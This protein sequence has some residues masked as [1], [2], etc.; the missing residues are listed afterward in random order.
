M[1]SATPP[2]AVDGRN[3]TP[4]EGFPPV[5]VIGMGVRLPDADTVE[6]LHALLLK[7]H[8]AVRP[9]PRRRLEMAGLDPDGVH[10]PMATLEGIDE[11]DRAFFGITPAEAEAMDPHQRL[12]LQLACAAV[13]NAGY[14]LSALRGR[15][16]GVFLSAPRPEYTALVG[17][18]SLLTMLGTAAPALAGR[19][20]Y[21]LGLRGP[22]LALET[23]CSSSLVALHYACRELAHGT[24][25]VALAGGL[26]LHLLPL[27][28]S[29]AAAFPEVMAA[30]GRCRAFDASAA[31][32]CQGEG[33]ALLLLKPLDR[34]L[35][36]GDTVHAVIRAIAVNHN[37]DRSNGFSAPGLPAQTEVITQAWRQAG[38][39]PARMDVLEAHGS[40]TRLGD[41]IEIEAVQRVLSAAGAGRH[42]C[43]V[44]SVKTNLGHLDHAAGITGLAKAILAVR[45]R[46][47][48][49]SL[50]FE[51]PNP[52]L[53]AHGE[54]IHV[55]TTARP[56]QGP[57]GVPMVAAVSAFSLTGTNVH[58]VVEGPPAPAGAPRAA[59]RADLTTV[60]AAT[61]AALAGR[62]ERL[63]ERVSALDAADLPDVQFTLNTGRD[64]HPCRV[65]FPAGDPEA[66]RSG[67]RDA[68]AAGGDG[69]AEPTVDRRLVLVIGEPGEHAPEPGPL[70]DA[71]PAYRDAWRECGPKVPPAVAHQYATGRLLRAVG[72]A[73]AVVVGIGSGKA[74]ARAL[75]GEL[76]LSEALAE[77]ASAPPADPAA[78]DAKA[79]EVAARL[80]GQQPSVLCLLG[81]PGPAFTSR[82]H[83]RWGARDRDGV[84]AEAAR[85]YET[86]VTP[87]WETWYAG[88]TR[89]R[90]E[91]PGY[92][93]AATPCWPEVRAAGAPAVAPVPAVER[94]APGGTADAE[95][96]IAGIW[97]SVLKIPGIE[98]LGEDTDY[99]ELGGNSILGLAVLERL[100]Q[101]FGVRL[102]L[103]ALY[104][105][106]TVRDLAAV[107]RGSGAGSA[108]P[109]GAAIPKAPRRE[110]YLPSHGQDALWFL[111]QLMPGLP[112]YNV[113][114]DLHLSGVLDVDA[115][116]TALA[117]LEAR[118]EVL[119]TRYVEVDGEP[120]IVLRPVDERELE[121]VD[122]SGSADPQRRLA[123]AVRLLRE[124]AAAPMDLT[125][126]PLYRKLLVR[127]AADDHILLLVA[128]H[129][130][131]DGWTPAILDRDLWE[132]Y[133]AAVQG[134]TPDLPDLPIGYQDFAAWQRER[135]AGGR[136]EELLR[137]WRAR[138]AGLRPLD[139]PDARPR[140]ERPSGR[141]AHYYFT[142]PAAVMGGLRALSSQQRTTLFTTMLTSLKTL[143]ARYSGVEDVVV[144]TTTAGRSV[145]E[146]L[147]LIGYFN[148]AV[149]LRTDLSGDPSF[150]DALARVR[151]T[152][153]GALE[154]DELPFSMLVADLQPTRDV[155][156]HPLFQIT[157]VHQ[158]LPENARD[159][160]PGL[161]YHPD[162][163]E[164]FAGLPPG[165]AKWDLSLAVWE[166]DGRAELPAVL[167][168][169]LD[170]FEEPQIARLA[171][172]FLTLLEGIVAD[173]D[174]PLSRLPLLD[175]PRRRTVLGGGR[176][177][178][179]RDPD[180]T[181]PAL[182]A[183]SAGESDEGPVARLHADAGRL[184][185]AL[186]AR[187]VRPGDPVAGLLGGERAAVALLGALTAGAVYVP[188]DPQLS[189]A[190]RA[191]VLEHAA[192]VLLVTDGDSV[193]P[194]P[195]AVLRMPDG[196]LPDAPA[197]EA[198]SAHRAA[199]ADPAVVVYRGTGDAVVLDHRALAAACAWWERQGGPD[200]DPADGP[201]VPEGAGPVELLDAVLRYAGGRDAA[202]AEPP[203]TLPG[204]PLPLAGSVPAGEWVALERPAPGVELYVLD[205]ALEPVPPGVTGEL[206]VGGAAVGLG[207]WRQPSA[208]AR[209]FPPD[210][211]S[212]RPG[213]R[214]RRTGL[215]ARTTAEGVVELRREG[216]DSGRP[217]PSAV[218]RARWDEGP[219]DLLEAALTGL[220]GAVLGRDVGHRDDFFD[221][222]GHSL[223]VMRVLTEVRRRCGVR[224]AVSVMFAHS[225]PE[226]LAGAV[227]A[228]GGSLDPRLAV[229]LQPLGEA[230]ALFC[231]HGD[232]D[233]LAARHAF[234]RALGSGAPVYAVDAGLGAAGCASA[235]RRARPA[236]PYRLLGFGAGAR[237]AEETAALLTAE[238]A[239][240]DF[241]GLV[242][243]SGEAAPRDAGAGVAT[244][245]ARL[246]GTGSAAELAAAVREALPSGGGPS[247]G[248]RVVDV[249]ATPSAPAPGPARVALLPD[250]AGAVAGPGGAT[251]VR[252]FRL[253][254]DVARSLGDPA[255]GLLASVAALLARL[256]GERDVVV[257]L[258]TPQA[259]DCLP[260]RIAVNPDATLATLV[261][262]AAAGIA[263]AEALRRPSVTAGSHPDFSVAVEV[264]DEE[265]GL[266]GPGLDT[267]HGRLDLLW[268]LRESG[269]ELRGAVLIDADRFRPRT[270]KRLVERW[271]SLV[272][273]AALSDG[274]L[275]S[276][277]LTDEA[278]RTALVGT[279]NDTARER[280]PHTTVAGLIRE[281]AVRAPGQVAVVFDGT[282]LTYRQ[283][284][285]MAARL[286]A[287][288]VERGAGPESV[289][290]VCAQRSP[291]L[292]VALVAVLYAGA[293]YL[294]LDPGY[295]AERLEYMVRDSGTRLVL[296]GP[297]AIPLDAAADA[298]LLDL[299]ADLW[300]LL[301][302]GSAPEPARVPGP[303]PGH[304][305]YVLYTSGSTGRPK[306]VVVEHSAVVNRLLWSQEFEPLRAE[307]RV[308]QKTP[309]SFDVSVWEF[310]APLVAGATMVLAA[311]GAQ[312]DPVGLA[313]LIGRER[314][315]GVHFV[316]SMLRL[317]L[318]GA[319]GAAL[320]GVR[321]MLCSGETLFPE[322]RQ[323][324]MDAS[325]TRLLN[326]YGPTETTVECSV[327]DCVQDSPSPTVPIGRPIANLRMYVLDE[328][329]RPCPVGAPGELYV[330]GAGL[331]RGYLGRPGLTAER[332]VPSPFGAPGERLYRTGDRA[333]VLDGGVVEFL[334]RVDDQ[335]KVR[336][337]RIEPG[338][339]ESVLS[340][341]PA[342]E[343]AAVAVHEAGPG[344]QR[345]V[346]HLV[347]TP[348]TSAE[349]ELR[350]LL[351]RAL[352]S[353]ML[354]GAYRWHESLPLN[355][356][357]K[358]D[359]RALT[360]SP[361]DLPGTPR[362]PQRTEQGAGSDV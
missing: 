212:G 108:A 316:P 230:P 36:E 304:P 332:F 49:P 256:T 64:D 276:L 198:G 124:A 360:A 53:A 118:H 273:R 143:L 272:R 89:R 48:Y 335:V 3:G 43:A 19:V 94:V 228:A 223:L 207:L 160:G 66:L 178:A 286:A 17:E 182:L 327:W 120:R 269:E 338:E 151:T 159:I 21:L 22:A 153:I 202:A 180:A 59:V 134:R 195:G 14:A 71:F 330:A 129:S 35:A 12:T 174:A 70:A 29:E 305:A 97:S 90:V 13:E 344:D 226:A 181:L 196:G 283:L 243:A 194:W 117:G 320:R 214:L 121:V 6:E 222:G 312:R 348:G 56:W 102:A 279:W 4:E 95:R 322:L 190:E 173:P 31:G 217:E 166:Y 26:N 69:E 109:A 130:V 302:A 85:L 172:C 317:F 280:D 76:P 239:D 253:E 162:R 65:A 352:P 146:V 203:V 2:P 258:R 73:P 325:S 147:D 74:V 343:A 145:P 251:T 237:L 148:N 116:R 165:I 33:G 297:G 38:M 257:G 299:D 298:G 329:L 241:V 158:N 132:L 349:D 139:L 293:A 331:A 99:F 296:T 83:H 5:A 291:E 208:T 112:L 171:D 341:H 249:P 201:R 23:G 270:A 199:P 355:P 184:A 324:V 209:D 37:G 138:L 238:G 125:T 313:E 175:G 315:T 30:G 306:G 288:L 294:P 42:A 308:L 218:P 229:A 77:A 41:M 319:G 242:D 200:A 358:L 104:Q 224:L 93:F 44:S 81:D 321:L 205:A 152:V 67:L 103:P 60:S 206:H 127:L 8:D 63:L 82:D 86:G 40:G 137:Y 84:L 46:T 110:Q 259:P 55:N 133:T 359:R 285:V 275:D 334:G 282:H 292:V 246:S 24:A 75:R 187:G 189:F 131:Y 45:F 340:G 122:L 27:E 221:L 268:K 18:G 210:P 356:S 266:A 219:A 58:V 274:A 216:P 323:A 186:T 346:A 141:G 281:Q 307:D 144:G 98:E 128:H 16:C 11:F 204:L 353:H 61:P 78:A 105:H 339:I 92:P 284:D 88:E 235:V 179:P 252:P 87:D 311:P 164:M 301:E 123:D 227:R 111:D 255:A 119:R 192:P 361:A 350:A 213:A 271:R 176:G 51:R 295:P 183:R 264:C 193:L 54:P 265:S 28:Q 15:R 52:Q 72:L 169:S 262:R 163:E 290:G 354:P 240:V 261:D 142:I 126:G 1:S 336:G 245:V 254:A 357:G 231:L 232:G 220:F 136:R 96:E 309:M 154:H 177:P 140:P 287:R 106:S 337:F 91:L 185:A 347:G 303:L 34:A 107:V 236:G 168:Y 50:H 113:P 188:C 267:P 300:A 233:D 79:R 345:L 191:A 225:T 247:D 32:T 167:E 314:V 250:R 115:L 150:R 326:L 149:P 342:V 263:A 215:A 260:V 318:A 20:S 68:L 80:S 101:R 100:N 7:G 9:V 248:G 39:S 197:P 47:L 234:A 157:Y 244:V 328:R 57:D 289:V 25:E 161:E 114:V 310:F 156:R 333:R 62:L 211:F 170:L 362:R 135:L 277:E 278:E 10:P 351:A 155:S